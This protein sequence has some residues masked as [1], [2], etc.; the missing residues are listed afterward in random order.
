MRVE[1]ATVGS[2]VIFLP[3]W[4]CPGLI[5]VVSGVAAGVDVFSC[6]GL[7]LMKK[8]RKPWLMHVCIGFNPNM[9]VVT[10]QKWW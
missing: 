6:W 2:F 9:G 7:T 3:I 10:H 8:Q 1:P 4:A 5:V